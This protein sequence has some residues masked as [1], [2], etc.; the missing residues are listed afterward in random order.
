MA[1]SVVKRD[2]WGGRIVDFLTVLKNLPLTRCCGAAA[3]L[4]GLVLADNAGWR[5]DDCQVVLDGNN[6]GNPKRSAAQETALIGGGNGVGACLG[7][8]DKGFVG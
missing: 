4:H 8:L 7:D 3:E 1:K 6:F 5:V 2:R